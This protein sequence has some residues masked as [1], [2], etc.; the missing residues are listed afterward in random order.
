MRIVI[1]QI[2]KGQRAK[3]FGKHRL[4]WLEKQWVNGLAVPAVQVSLTCWNMMLLGVQYD[5]T[6]LHVIIK[7]QHATSIRHILQS[8]NFRQKNIF[9][10]SLI[11]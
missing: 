9:Q 6:A 5:V 8:R 3:K 11:S 4:I 1:F 7:L 2:H 10:L